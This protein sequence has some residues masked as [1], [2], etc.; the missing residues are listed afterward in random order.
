MRPLIIERPDLQSQVQRYGYLSVTLICWVLWL[1]LFVP[2][3]ALAAWLLGAGLIYQVMV[4]DLRVEDLTDLALNYGTGIVAL[5]TVFLT[6]AVTSYRRF[7]HADRR[8]APVPV[9][10]TG[11]RRS[12]HLTRGEFATL[13]LGWRVVLSADQLGR[14]FASGVDLQEPEHEAPLR[15]SEAA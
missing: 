2:L 13:R 5:V 6:W 11:I 15:H 14:M 9:D 3:L 8:R 7:R 4:Q 1:Y 10:D 12:H